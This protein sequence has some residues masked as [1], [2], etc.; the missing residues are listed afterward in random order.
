MEREEAILKLKE[1]LKDEKIY[2]TVHLKFAELQKVELLVVYLNEATENLSENVLN[3]FEKNEQ[4]EELD[5]WAN[6]LIEKASRYIQISKDREKLPYAV[7]YLKEGYQIL[8]RRDFEKFLIAIEFNYPSDMKFYEIRRSVLKDWCKYLEDLE[9]GRL[10]GLSISAP[11]RTGKALSLDSGILTPTGW[12]KM[13]DIKVG[14][15]AIGADGKA[16]KVIGV[17]PQG[18]KEMYKVVFDDKTE[19][20][21]SGD[22]LWTVRTN[23]DRQ[24]YKGK[25]KDR[26]LKTTDM[27]FD[28]KLKGGNNKYSIDFVEPVEFENKLTE[29]DLDP[30]ILGSMLSNGHIGNDLLTYYTPHQECI[31]KIQEKIPKSD[32]LNVKLYDNVYKCSFGKKIIG[33]EKNKTLQ[34]MIEYS[35]NGKTAKDKFVPKKYLYSSIE[36]RIELLRGLMDGDG[37]SSNNQIRYVTISEQLAKDVV[38][39]VKSLGGRATCNK[40]ANYKNGKRVNDRYD[41]QIS[42]DINPFY[43]KEKTE[44]FKKKQKNKYKYITS[45]ERIPDEEC[46]CI[47]VDNES[48][49]FVTDGYNLTHNTTIGGRFFTWCILRHPSKSCFFVSHTRSNGDKVI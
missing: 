4:V 2:N 6:Y 16:A 49:L 28:Y 14:D 9:Y 27:L 21:C 8:G 17:Y 40:H 10:K 19:V 18:V 31:D 41:I 25:I 12:V 30:Y 43:C 3:G 26:V 1:D 47:M 32:R 48:H 22:H 29:D 15:Y 7:R 13:R 45:I 44:K 39:L 33:K 11:P 38:E 23:S 5:K 36:N 35:L 46:Q 34:K 24:A 20:K 42:I 37:S